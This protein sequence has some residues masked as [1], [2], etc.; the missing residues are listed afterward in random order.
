MNICWGYKIHRC[1][2]T[3]AGTKN[4][5]WLLIAK[6]ETSEPGIGA[7]TLLPLGP[8]VADDSKCTPDPTC[9]Q[10]VRK[11]PALG[12]SWQ[13]LLYKV[14]VLHFYALLLLPAL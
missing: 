9:A 14:P 7:I 11:P 12:W 10:L 1:K 13:S 3:S 6:A 4:H 5:Q 2:A 8:H